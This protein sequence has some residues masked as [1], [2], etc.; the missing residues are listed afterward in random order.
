MIFIVKI[1]MQILECML[2]L[3]ESKFACTAPVRSK[4]N[5]TAEP[6][7]EMRDEEAD[8]S[9]TL[10]ERPDSV[11]IFMFYYNSRTSISYQL[12]KIK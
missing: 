10:E 5:S 1:T 8:L 9:D 4:I 6:G 12:N 3:T 7:R 11:S 2:T